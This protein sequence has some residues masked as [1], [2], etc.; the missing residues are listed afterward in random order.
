MKPPVP[1]GAGGLIRSV[2]GCVTGGGILTRA[3]AQ[4]MLDNGFGVDPFIDGVSLPTVLTTPAGNVYCKSRNWNDPNNQDEQSLAFFLP[5][6][7][8][9]VVFVNSMVAGQLGSTNNLR[10]VVKQ[11]Y[12]NNLTTQPPLHL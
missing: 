9:L 12:L 6:D 11:A 8:E 5:E 2:T 1:S 7:M 3:A 4:A 10:E